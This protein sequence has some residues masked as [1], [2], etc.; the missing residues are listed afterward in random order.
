MIADNPY[1]Q[2]L[3]DSGSYRTLRKVGINANISVIDIIMTDHNGVFVTYQ[4]INHNT[5]KKKYNR[6]CLL[7]TTL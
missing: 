3:S 5:A 2:T 7:I 1:T 4:T 6:S